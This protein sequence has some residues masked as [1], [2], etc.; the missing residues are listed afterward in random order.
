MKGKGIVVTGGASGL[1]LATVELLAAAGARVAIIDLN[2]SVTDG[3]YGDAAGKR[4]RRARH[5][6]RHRAKDRSRARCLPRRRSRLGRVDGLVNCAGV[7]PRRPI[8]EISRRGLGF[9]LEGQCARDLQHDGG[10]GAAHAQRSRSPARCAAA[11]SMSRRSTPSRPIRRTPTMPRPRRRWSAS[12]AR[13][14]SS[15]PPNR[16][17]STR[18]HRQALRPRRRRVRASSASLPRTRPRAQCRARRNRRVDRHPAR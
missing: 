6:R 12:R 13:S 18:S 14:R 3:A 9:R 16:S 17:S 5:R 11:S 2:R 7:Y 8:L 10:R 1:G 4:P 15:S